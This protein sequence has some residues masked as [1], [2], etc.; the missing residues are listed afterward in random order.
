MLFHDSAFCSDIKP[1]LK[2]IKAL[3]PL[4]IYTVFGG[5][6]FWRTLVTGDDELLS[7]KST[8]KRKY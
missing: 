4:S 7:K 6:S 1:D 2:H 5:H 3:E 8:A